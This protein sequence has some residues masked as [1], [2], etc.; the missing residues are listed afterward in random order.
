MQEPGPSTVS[1]HLGEWHHWK[2]QRTLPSSTVIFTA[3]PPPWPRGLRFQSNSCSGAILRYE[4]NIVKHYFESISD[5]SWKPR[6]TNSK[7]NY[8][9]S[10]ILAKLLF[11]PFETSLHLRSR[12]SQSRILYEPFEISLHPQN[13]EL[14]FGYQV[15]FRSNACSFPSVWWCHHIFPTASWHPSVAM[16]QRCPFRPH[17]RRRLPNSMD[18]KGKSSQETMG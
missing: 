10:N 18:W 15:R 9:P 4:S 7:P 16:L 11:H 14:I 17:M 1:R 8:S 2:L 3:R 6:D 12:T 5:W 13:S